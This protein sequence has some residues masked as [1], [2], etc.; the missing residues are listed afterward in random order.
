MRIWRWVYV[1]TL[2]L[3]LIV[4]LGVA[5]PLRDIDARNSRVSQ[6]IVDPFWPKPLPNDPV[7]GNVIG[8]GVDS[9]DHV[10]IIQ[11]GAGSLEP[12][13][14]YAAANPP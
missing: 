10:Y 9:K 1:G 7:M 11:R 8:V 2:L 5:T 14:I 12:T 4:G 3:T 6:Y 13:E